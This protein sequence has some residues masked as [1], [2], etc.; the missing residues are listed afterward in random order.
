VTPQSEYDRTIFNT[1]V[2]ASNAVSALAI[3]S[4]AFR[5]P[6]FDL[7]EIKS[8]IESI[9]QE[10][11]GA[12]DSPAFLSSQKLYET[13]FTA[14][15]IKRS[16][17]GT[18]EGLR[19]LT[20]EDVLAY[21]QKYYRPSNAILTIVG[22]ADREMILQEA[23]RLYADL[24]NV[25]VERD[26]SPPEPA[27]TELRYAWRRGPIQ[28][29]HVAMGFHTPG[30]S[31]DE[32]RAL[33][34]LAAIV[35][36]GRASRL[37]QILRDQKNLITAGTAGVQTYSDVGM[38]E[39]QLTT[40][41]PLE[42][43]TAVLAE[44]GSI[45]R[46]GVSAEALARAKLNL[47]RDYYQQVE[48]A[49]GASNAIAYSEA[50]GDWKRLSRYV[51]EIDSVSAQRVTQ[52]ATKY[53]TFENL[54]VVEYLPESMERYLSPTEYRA[55]VLDKV[56]AAIE[57]R[58]EAEL[59]VAPLPS[60]PAMVADTIGSIQQRS[61]LR[62]PAVHIL[63]DHRLPLVSFGIFFPGGR[64]LETE[65]NAGI[66]ELMLRTAL[67]GAGSFSAADIARRVENAGARL[68]VVNEPD[69][70]GYTLSGFPGRMEQAL[71]V[72]IEVLQNPVFDEVQVNQE[73]GMQISRIRS[74][75]D[76]VVA[77]P[78]SLFMQT[79]F[80]DHSY[81]RP[82][83]GTEAGIGMLTGVQ[84]RQWF[85]EHMRQTLPTVVIVGDTSGTGLIAPI[86]D[87]LTNED[88][89]PR[90]IL[91]SPRIQPTVKSGESV[92]STKWG[93]GSLVY[94]FPGVHRSSTDR[95]AFDALASML[96]GATNMAN[97]KGGAF[98]SAASFPPGKEAEV[99]AAL[100]AEYTK[101]RQNT[102]SVDDLRRAIAY[103]IG[104]RDASLQ[105]R[106]SRVLEY[107]RAIYSGAGVPSVAGYSTAMRAV[108][109]PQLNSAIE[110]HLQPTA[111]R[112]GIVRGQASQ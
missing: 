60:R 45:R 52:A 38:F 35:G 82:A 42:A 31:S 92:E 62:G 99:R 12:N 37:N 3:Q 20:S 65:R 32:T 64:L 61:I 46:S 23:V 40:A 71:R 87:A 105:S 70:F 78:Q 17:P 9:I 101:L 95:Y 48:T 74:V 63:E 10:A 28:E 90:D 2:P 102:V 106:E 5:R 18:A 73:R 98:F 15:R 97:V 75:K 44:L 54:S 39:V 24:E 77:Y 51:T 96:P 36:D 59:P 33:E 66:T 4:E 80:A 41:S 1:I 85:R 88:L 100:D 50:R 94:G 89:K 91:G 72:L 86:A 93:E 112:L 26:A 29:A 11:R 57:R 6:S 27:Q 108:T 81:A 30:V 22:A 83:V 69:F 67:R 103:S 84:L 47:A 21:Y 7:E 53:L 58:N 55:Q 8:E 13:A 14:H 34:V 68:E 49:Q 16:S 76:D 110:R 104:Q 107:A 111:L 109:L 79:L 56:E 25:P 19:A 43:A